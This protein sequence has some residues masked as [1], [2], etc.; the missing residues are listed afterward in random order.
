MSFRIKLFSKANKVS[1]LAQDAYTEVLNENFIDDF[2]SLLQ[3]LATSKGRVELN[4]EKVE[5]SM[6]E[7]H[8]VGISTVG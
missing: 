5:R 3:D 8:K 6:H 4:V 2:A 1:E 7:E